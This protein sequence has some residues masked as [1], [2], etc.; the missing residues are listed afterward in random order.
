MTDEQAEPKGGCVFQGTF[1]PEGTQFRATYKRETFT[2]SI[3]EG[4]WR[5]D[6]GFVSTSPSDAAV[7]ISGTKVNGWKFLAI[8]TSRRHRMEAF[9]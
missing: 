3:S 2:A 6:E 9:S 8:Q 1:F 5:D 7:K 4:A